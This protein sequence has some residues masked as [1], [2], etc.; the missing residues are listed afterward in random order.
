M[1]GTGIEFIAE[2]GGGSWHPVEN[3]RDGHLEVL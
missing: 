1:R 3:E 2:N